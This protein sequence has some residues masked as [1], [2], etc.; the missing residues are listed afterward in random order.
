MKYIATFILL[1][2]SIPA[3]SQK[4]ANIWYYGYGGGIDFNSGSPVNI[5]GGQIS[6]QEG[7]ATLSDKTTGQLLFYTDGIKAWT[8][9]HNVMP[10]GTGLLGSPTSTQSGIIVPFPDDYNKFYV[11]S[12]G[13]GGLGDF[14]YSVVDITLNGGLGDIT[15]K[16]QKLLSNND[17]KIIAA[18]HANN[19]DYWVLT[20][21]THDGS[22]KFY[23]FLINSSGVQTPVITEL[24][25]TIGWYGYLKVS[26]D[27][28]KVSIV[29]TAKHYLFDFDANTG[30]VSN[31]VDLS[32]APG[33]SYG[34]EFS[35]DVTKV[36]VSGLI[37]TY[38][39]DLCAT[40]IKSSRIL[41]DAKGGGMQIGPDGRI[42]VADGSGTMSRINKPN[43][44]GAACDFVLDGGI[45]TKCGYGVPTFISSFFKDTTTAL[46]VVSDKPNG[47]CE[48]E[49]A[50]LSVTGGKPP[51]TWSPSAGLNTT[52]GSVVTASPNTTTTYTVASSDTTSSPCGST[53]NNYKKKIAV[54]VH[55]L[56]DAEA[57]NDV[58]ICPGGNVKLN[59]TGGTIYHW[60]PSA[61]LSADNISNPAASPAKTTTYH[62]TVSTQFGCSDDDSVKVSVG[63][64]MSLNIVKLNDEFC[65]KKNASAKV[66]IGGNTAALTFKWSSVPQQTDSIIKN[67]S[68]GKYFVTVTDN[69]GCSGVDSVT[70]VNIPGPSVTVTK[71]ADAACGK[72]DGKAKA[73]VNG[74]TAPFSFLWNSVPPVDSS[75]ADGLKAGNYT[76]T[77]TDANNCS[78]A[79]AVSINS[80]SAFAYNIFSFDGHCG[81]ADGYAYIVHPPDTVPYIYSWSN[82]HTE[83]TIYNLIAGIYIVTITRDSCT[84]ID[85]AVVGNIQGIEA[86]FSVSPGLT[87]TTED[88]FTFR[89]LSQ[90]SVYWYWDFG[91]STSYEGK[92]IAHTFPNTGT[93]KVVLLVKDEYGCR[94]TASK[95]I[96]IQNPFTIY[97]PNAFTP[98][99]DKLN[100]YFGPVISN[101]SYDEYEFRI[102]NRWGSQIFHTSVPPSGTQNPNCL[103]DGKYNGRKVQQDVYVYRII[104]KDLKSHKHS[105]FG[106]VSLIR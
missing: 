83:D 12:V 72:S 41:I 57:G 17:E 100:D 64:G 9:N 49:S 22:Q 84:V 48:G 89:D 45:G 53:V 96:Q 105:Y 13:A 4:E 46:V 94:D 102:F 60:S 77:V 8:R 21:N 67:V 50:H 15:T 14:A 47:I 16:N 40:D 5:S 90:G 73:D 55:P 33:I 23:A 75:Y 54:V 44:T 82:L 59:A 27:A 24:G 11:F 32:D 6:T 98:D 104:V 42:Y 81:Q 63:L 2:L 70:F 95:I 62:V 51:Y 103:W 92:D 106:R 80:L 65:G 34:T 69:T 20:S 28:S 101:F 43:L 26:P 68:A 31:P 99:D 38:Q 58:S 29:S 1:C 76:V 85:T 39:Y 25:V 66:S 37:N 91:D 93:Y 71:I 74:G 52:T 35:P 36:Y 7:C 88:S 30:K 97:I 78:A 56:P 10:N 3:F 18:K 61:G 79:G 87:G 19:T 86:A